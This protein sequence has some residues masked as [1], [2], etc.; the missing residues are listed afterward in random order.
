MYEE[1]KDALVSCGPATF[2]AT[3]AKAVT[4]LQLRNKLSQP[5]MSEAQ[6]IYRKQ[7]TTQG[8]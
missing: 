6:S 8:E 5:S 2:E 7:N 1:A 3:Q 4:L